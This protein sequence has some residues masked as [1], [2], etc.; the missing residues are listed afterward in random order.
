MGGIPLHSSEIPPSVH[1]LKDTGLTRLAPSYRRRP[2]LS[3]CHTAA[4]IGHDHRRRSSTWSHNC[5]SRKTAW[6]L[7][8]VSTGGRHWLTPSIAAS[9]PTAGDRCPL[10]SHP[11][12]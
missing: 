3:S 6:R 5:T 7:A 1:F 12:T 11:L 2:S 8:A 10:H 4:S 9:A